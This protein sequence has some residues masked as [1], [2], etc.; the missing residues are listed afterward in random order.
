[1]LLLS[2]SDTDIKD[3]IP[4]NNNSQNMW[5]NL[6]IYLSNYGQEDVTGY[7]KFDIYV[8]NR[9]LY[10]QIYLINDNNTIEQND[11]YL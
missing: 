2:K 4:L 10:E 5:K 3:Y 11:E 6:E 9:V 1:M 7:I 8:V